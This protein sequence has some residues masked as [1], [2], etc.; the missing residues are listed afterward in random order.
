[1]QVS[2]RAYYARTKQPETTEK[3]KEN[4]NYCQQHRPG[5][6]ILC[7]IP[8]LMRNRLIDRLFKANVVQEFYYRYK[9]CLAGQSM[10]LLT[11]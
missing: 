6:L 10:L 3:T 9:A 7:I 4:E 5:Q 8:A 11:F 2:T 1:M